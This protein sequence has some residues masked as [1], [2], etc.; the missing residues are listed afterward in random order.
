MPASMVAV[1]H[2]A[3][4]RVV[5]AGVSHVE[6]VDLPTAYFVCTQEGWGAAADVIEDSKP[7]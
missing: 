7:A 1:L 6:R 2:S 4:R 5:W 3:R